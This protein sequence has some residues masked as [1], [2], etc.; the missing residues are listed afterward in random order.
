MIGVMM[1]V[2]IP[3]Y[4]LAHIR[5]ARCLPHRGTT[6]HEACGCGMPQGVRR[7][8]SSF[9]ASE[10]VSHRS[11]GNPLLWRNNTYKAP[12]E[13]MFLEEF[14]RCENNARSLKGYARWIDC[15]LTLEEYARPVGPTLMTRDTFDR[16]E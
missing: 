4:L 9:A 7:V 12:V 11:R 15:V 8:Q 2:G 1:A 5:K 16:Y 6:L 13:K 3:Q 14:A 10:R